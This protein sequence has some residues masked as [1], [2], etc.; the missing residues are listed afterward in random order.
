M[1]KDAV[2]IDALL[3]RMSVDEKIAQLCAAWFSISQDGSLSIRSLVGKEAAP[4]SAY[5]LIRDGIGQITRPFGTHPVDISACRHHVH[6]LQR[7]LVEK[8][9]LGIPAMFHEECLAGM[10]AKGTTQF[11]S[12]INYGSMWDPVLVQKIGETIHRELEYAGIHQGLA[13]VLDVSHDVRWGR[14]EESMGEDPYLVG[15]TSCAYIRGLQGEERSILATPKHFLGHSLSEGGRNH[16]PVNIGR[17]RLY[18]HYALPFEMAVKAAH[19][20]SIMPAYHDIDGEPC[21][22]SRSYLTHLLRDRWGFDGIIVSDYEAISQLCHNHHIASDMA[23]AAA[24]AVHAG[25]DIELP[26]DTAYREGL[27]RALAKNLV[28]IDE[29]NALVRR[30]LTQ[31]MRLGLFDRPYGPN[32]PIHVDA[33]LNHQLA[34]DA[35]CA[36]SILLENSGILPLK[37][38]NSIALIGPLADEPFAMYAGYSFP[39]HLIGA[40]QDTSSI[41]SRSLTVRKALERM[42]EG[43]SV[44]YA[45]GCRILAKRS[46]KQVVFPGE[47][48]K[49]AGI[50]DSLID[51]DESEIAEAVTLAKQSDVAVI[52]VGDMAG[53]FRN[54]TV[55]EGSDADSLELPGI[56]KKL[57]KEIIRTETPV[58][59]VLSCGRPYAYQPSGK[60]A[61]AVL[62][63]WL[64][65]EGGGE[66][67]AEMLLGIKSPGGRLPISYVTDVGMLPYTYNHYQNSAGV[68]Q[69]P[70]FTARYPFGYGLSYSR[71][72]PRNISV[73]ESVQPPDGMFTIHCTIENT[74]KRAER[75][76]IQ[77]Y[78]RDVLAGTVRPQKELKGFCSVFLGI[79]Q[80]AHVVF[81][82]P[83]DML[84]SATDDFQRIV[85][86]GEFVIMLGSSSEDIWFTQSVHIDGDTRILPED[87]NMMTDVAIRYLNLP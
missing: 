33:D 71:F 59:V 72:T 56:Q 87:W 54:G 61:D 49:D 37:Q 38:V 73:A 14:T 74:G 12:G 28:S 77:L 1:A 79:G 19:C 62:L 66:A 26:S 2:Q 78:V 35:A 3:K 43:V 57:I 20:G 47:V 82:L 41:P 81:S 67:I 75:D 4:G 85:E 29:V 53:L 21:S 5:D 69:H 64:A 22:S 10:M 51:Y 9:R 58:I 44:Q 68:P 60:K 27:K 50:Y 76:V 70:A 6:T 55:G 13:P 24:L 25:I 63:T 39:T 42:A 80:S 46:G 31:K 30:V 45:R 86:P 84:N 36:S 17:R 52:V 40:D 15:L 7:Y 83:A 16:A 18:E 48:V 8:T 34:V 65:G 32:E 23:D 11:P